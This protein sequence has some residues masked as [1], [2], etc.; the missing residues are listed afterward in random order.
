MPLQLIFSVVVSGVTIDRAEVP[1]TLG[2]P[3]LRHPRLQGDKE[4]G[5]RPNQGRGDAARLTIGLLCAAASHLGSRDKRSDLVSTS[6]ICG[7]RL[8][9]ER[10][11][12]ENDDPASCIGG[13]DRSGSTGYGGFFDLRSGANITKIQ[14]R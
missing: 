10:G 5:R 1:G 8:S 3:E 6:S 4:V 14:A 13:G 12:S 7:T 2:V 9:P 11:G